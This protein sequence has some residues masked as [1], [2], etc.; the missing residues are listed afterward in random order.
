MKSISNSQRPR[1]LTAAEMN[2]IV[3]G[4]Y[5]GMWDRSTQTGTIL[6]ENGVIVSYVNG[7]KVGQ[8]KP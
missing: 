2:A 6:Q 8:T 3:G 5:K 7:K 4:C 1:V